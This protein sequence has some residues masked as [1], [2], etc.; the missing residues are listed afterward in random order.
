MEETLN[1]EDIL[2]VIKKNLI[3]IISLGLLFGAAAAFA[4]ALIMTPQYEANT[5]VLVTQSQESSDGAVNNQDIQASLQLVNTYWDII[6][7]P[8]VLD[9][10]VEN[11]G[12]EQT[13]NAL[14]NKI[15]VNNQ[16]QSQV[17]T[18]T[19]SDEFPENA[20]TIANEVADVFQER[21]SEVMNVD[22]VSILT[23]ADVGQDPSPVSPQPLVNIAI[24][25]I[26]GVLLALGI[27]FLREFLDK[28]VKTEEEVEKILDLPVLGT[29]AKFDK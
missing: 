21:V 9:D 14:A 22:N 23:T 12:L 25:L 5:Q 4:T 8:T 15:T 7:S 2:G 3:M 11:L 27:A 18:I 29:V 16:D 1:L 24:G 26:L 19:V 10:V 20:E 13:S 6:L 17:L 28:R